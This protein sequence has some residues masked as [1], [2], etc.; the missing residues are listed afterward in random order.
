[1]YGFGF[2]LHVMCIYNI[3]NC[4]LGSIFVDYPN[5]F[6]VEKPVTDPHFPQ[7]NEPFWTVILSPV[8]SLNRSLFSPRTGRHCYG[9][10][11]ILAHYH[12]AHTRTQTHINT[13]AHAHTR[14]SRPLKRN[15]Q[16][17]R[18]GYT[19]NELIYFP[20]SHAT[21]HETYPFQFPQWPDRMKNGSLFQRYQPRLETPESHRARSLRFARSP[22]VYFIFFF[23]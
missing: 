13:H 12:R 19:E 21:K 8:Y 18:T 7:I 10:C 6:I 9:S 3:T 22:I 23:Q 14:R 17:L 5:S 20:F 2:L 1:M 11:I 15:M 4:H 16:Y